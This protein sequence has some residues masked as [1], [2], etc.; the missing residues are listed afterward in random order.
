MQA[1]PFSS[2]ELLV[3]KNRSLSKFARKTIGISRVFERNL[4]RVYDGNLHFFG[5]LTF[6]RVCLGRFRSDTRH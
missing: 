2:D 4:F 5:E 3:E 6:C 1:W